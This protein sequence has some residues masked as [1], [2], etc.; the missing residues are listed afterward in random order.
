MRVRR[1][2]ARAMSARKM[3]R[4]ALTVHAPDAAHDQLARLS[5]IAKEKHARRSEEAASLSKCTVSS[6]TRQRPMKA[7]L[8][9]ATSGCGSSVWSSSRV[10]TARKTK[11]TQRFWEV[12]RPARVALYL[13]HFLCPNIPRQYHGMKEVKKAAKKAKAFETQ[14]I[15]K[16]L[17]APGLVCFFVDPSSGVIG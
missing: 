17:K 11:M 9:R 6:Q 8:D 3:R 16:K 12:V 1:M 2:G 5:W 14:R 15:V 13:P 7:E 4:D 10:K